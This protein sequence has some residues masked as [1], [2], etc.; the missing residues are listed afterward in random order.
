MKNYLQIPLNYPVEF[1]IYSQ[2]KAIN[3]NTRLTLKFE[4]FTINKDY[5][6]LKLLNEC[7]ISLK[8]VN[9]KVFIMW[10]EDFTTNSENEALNTTTQGSRKILGALD[11][12]VERKKIDEDHV[13][14]ETYKKHSLSEDKKLTKKRELGENIY[15]FNDKKNICNSEKKM[16]EHEKLLYRVVKS[17]TSAPIL[18]EEFFIP[19]YAKDKSGRRPNS[20]RIHTKYS[21]FNNR[22]IKTAHSENIWS[23]V[24]EYD[25]L[26]L[27][28]KDLNWKTFFK[29]KVRKIRE[30]C[31]YFKEVSKYC[32]E[33]FLGKE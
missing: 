2:I 1:D 28:T 14:N 22:M 31:R 7:D 16:E 5:Q 4:E 12:N 20:E 17:A 29:I 21:F 6:N 19:S 32:I 23:S 10:S 24:P 30:S 33:D 26:E 15:N 3:K 18:D 25:P 8:P 27:N 13:N 9:F 11:G